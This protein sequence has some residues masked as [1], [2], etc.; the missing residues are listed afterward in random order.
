[1]AGV[2]SQTRE[3]VERNQR[4]NEDLMAEMV[5]R[6]ADHTDSVTGLLKRVTDRVECGQAETFEHCKR[7]ISEMSGRMLEQTQL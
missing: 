7:M 6:L 1:M 3:L 4:V 2:L 5:G